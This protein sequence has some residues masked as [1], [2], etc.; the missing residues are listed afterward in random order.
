MRKALGV[1]KHKC[2]PESI[3]FLNR[4]AGKRGSVDEIADGLGSSNLRDPEIQQKL[5][6]EYLKDFQVKSDVMS[7]G[8]RLNTK[9][10]QK[11]ESKIKVRRNVNWKLS[12]IE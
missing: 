12:K 3:S 8:Y 9:Y 10:N 11:I 4:A 6:S 5:I 1:A 2:N 7:M